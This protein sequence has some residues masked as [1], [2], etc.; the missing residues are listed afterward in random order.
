M[1]KNEFKNKF[2]EKINKYRIKIKNLFLVLIMHK[3]SNKIKLKE[4]GKDVLYINDSPK[5]TGSYLMILL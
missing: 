1:I 4:E 5:Y 3:F 2:A